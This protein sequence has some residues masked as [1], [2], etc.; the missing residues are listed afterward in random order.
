MSTAFEKRSHRIKNVESGD[1]CRLEPVSVL[2]RVCNSPIWGYQMREIN[3]LKDIRDN[4]YGWDYSIHGD[5]RFNKFLAFPGSLAV[6]GNLICEEPLVVY[7][8]LYVSGNIICK[9]E[10]V[11]GGVLSC[12]GNAELYGQV[13]CRGPVLVE[14]SLTSPVE[15]QAG[16]TVTVHGDKVMRKEVVA[17]SSGVVR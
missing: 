7:G 10:T 5:F 12:E 6:Y 1:R 16:G 2:K 4:C 8:Y 14:G 3:A 11:V 17:F 15:L 13:S 9:K